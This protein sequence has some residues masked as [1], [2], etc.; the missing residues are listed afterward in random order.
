[1]DKRPS[2]E[3]N[4]KVLE[5][6]FK[7]LKRKY[8]P[9]VLDQF[10]TPNK[11]V[12]AIIDDIRASTRGVRAGQAFGVAGRVGAILGI[13]AIGVGAFVGHLAGTDVEKNTPRFNKD[14]ADFKQVAS[15]DSSVEQFEGT[16][17][18]SAPFNIKDLNN[19]E[20]EKIRQQIIKAG[21]TLPGGTLTV[22]SMRQN[23]VAFYL[24]E[25]AEKV[26]GW[27]GVPQKLFPVLG[28]G[29]PETAVKLKDGRIAMVSVTGLSSDDAAGGVASLGVKDRVNKD[30]AE[31]RGNVGMEAIRKLFPPGTV[32]KR[33]E[34]REVLVDPKAIEEFKKLAKDAGMEPSALIKNFN[35]KPDDLKL[36]PAH[37]KEWLTKN[38]SSAR[39]IEFKMS[40]ELQKGS[41]VTDRGF[42]WK[43]A[44]GGAIATPA[45]ILLILSMIDARRK[46]RVYADVVD[47]APSGSR[48]ISKTRR[49]GEAR[50]GSTVTE[51]EKK[52]AAELEK[53]ILA[54]HKL[55]DSIS[56]DTVVTVKGKKITLRDAYGLLMLAMEVR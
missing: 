1:M 52:S 18:V 53:K 5:Q 10:Y 13:P 51:G 31:G 9:D 40:L 56:W 42:N 37:I 49:Y 15:P 35:E 50:P 2:A 22:D 8:D 39:G 38:L 11:D 14:V 55:N 36:V 32:V 21:I 3:S 24:D 16:F 27:V 43:P 6:N 34:A 28:L 7:D 44:L 48:P 54:L 41:Q 26:G 29:G 4:E 12:P 25:A 23:I 33:L 20:L 47:S 30:L 19:A 46:R 45:L 17:R